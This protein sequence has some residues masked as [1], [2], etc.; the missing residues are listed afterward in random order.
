MFTIS[1]LGVTELRGCDGRPETRAASCFL[2]APGARDLVEFGGC[3]WG[4]LA[5]THARVC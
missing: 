4:L 5:L 2:I 3:G 1:L